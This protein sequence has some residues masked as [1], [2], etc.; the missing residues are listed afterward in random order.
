L[1]RKEQA[2]SVPSFGIHVSEARNLLIAG[3]SRPESAVLMEP[4]R[5]QETLVDR[6]CE[7]RRR[8]TRIKASRRDG[9]LRRRPPITGVDLDETVGEA[10][11]LRPLLLLGKQQESLHHLFDPRLGKRCSVVRTPGE[12]SV[13]TMLST[14]K[15]KAV[16]LEASELYL[17]GRTILSRLRERSADSRVIF[18]DVEGSWALLMECESEETNDLLIHPCSMDALE[19]T[20]MDVLGY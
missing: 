10:E 19:E 14:L 12:A 9:I 7:T 8:G 16:L 11:T 1:G 2:F 5:R 6:K 15:P 17:E 20:L 13:E 3:L 4:L 18:L